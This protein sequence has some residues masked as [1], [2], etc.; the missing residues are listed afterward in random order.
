[1]GAHSVKN[2]V[3]FGAGDVGKAVFE[4]LGQERI[5]CF[6]DNFPKGDSHCGLA[7]VGF[8]E[9][10]KIYRS[11]DNTV[12][13]V[14]SYNYSDVISPQLNDNGMGRHYVW[15][16]EG[17]P[18]PLPRREEYH[19]R[20]LL[21]DF[22]IAEYKSVAVYGYGAGLRP[23]LETMEAQG[24][25]GSVK[26]ILPHSPK[27]SCLP[28]YPSIAVCDDLKRIEG[29]IDLLV[30]DVRRCDS[31][32]HDYVEST[33]VPFAVADLRKFEAFV[34][35]KAVL[36][37][38]D[39]H[40]GERC[41]VVGNGPSLR[42]SDLD[43]LREANAI[44]FGANKI[45]LAFGETVWRP[46]YY[47]AQDILMLT[48]HPKEISEMR[49]RHKFIADRYPAFWSS[50]FSRD[51]IRFHI[52]NE[53]FLP[54]MPDFSPDFSAYS[55]EGSTV[56]YSAL[57]LA[58]YMGFAEIYLLGV[59]FS[60]G[61]IHEKGENHFHPDYVGKGDKYGA[62]GEQT[63]LLAYRK[64]EI[65]S[66]LHGFRIYNAT[67]GGKLEVFERVDFDSLFSG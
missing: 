33:P 17:L 30:T 51:C 48:R 8:D 57:Q 24:A 58:A 63:S 13:I 1:M 20:K 54:N 61:G 22:G 55:T 60:F 53:V 50:D 36:P 59:D 16:R 43:K 39:M 4:I 14:A 41:F 66:R 62:F 52:K 31:R 23:L 9:L 10:K 45:F 44:C 37:F 65:Y 7:V 2:I 56:T 40:K 6:A 29:E 3:I 38:R 46:D 35:N 15:P 64:A 19:C 28:E 34:Q 18:C 42:M 26:Y 12:V 32:W 21:A 27:D 5:L 25:I 67:R 11:D 49:V 47:M